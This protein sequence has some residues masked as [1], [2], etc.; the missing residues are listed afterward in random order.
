MN[1][2][3]YPLTQAQYNTY[4][5]E[6]TAPDTDINVLY[7]LYIINEKIDVSK[8]AE[9]VN[10]FVKQNDT[11]RTRIIVEDNRPFSYIADYEEIQIPFVDLSGK[12]E[13]EIES[14]FRATGQKPFVFQN[15]PLYDFRIVKLS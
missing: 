2:K 7:H 9:A 10:L 6:I 1:R 8:M 5:M 3:Y 15:S 13:Q 12:T 14:W 4:S 11:A